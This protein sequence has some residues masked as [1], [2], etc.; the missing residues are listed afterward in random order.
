MVVDLA[1][2]VARARVAPRAAA[3]DEEGVYPEDI[4]QVFKEA[5]LLGLAV[6]E[7]YGGMGMGTLGLVLAVEEVAKYCCASGLILLLTRL[8]LAPIML[9][10][11]EEQKQKYARGIAEGRVR[12][13]FGLTE[14]DCGSDAAAIRTTAVRRGDHYVLNGTKRFISGTT[15]A[16]FFTIAAKTDPAAGSRGLSLLV[17][18]KGTSGLSL[19][20]K[21]NKMGVRGVPVTEIIMEDCRVPAENLL[22]QENQGFKTVMHTLNS[23]RP[24]VASRGIGLAE[25]ALQ[26]GIDYARER[27]A[28]GQP[29]IEFQGLQW[30]IADMAIATEASRL[31]TYRAAQYVD[32]GKYTREY[33]H[34]LSMAKTMA[35]DTAVR[36]ATDALQLLG[37]NGYMKEYPMERFYRDAKQ[38]QIVEGINQIQRN[39]IAKSIVDGHLHW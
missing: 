28:F 23:L 22:G 11:T 26:Y 36:V 1:R 7:E 10:G 3:I 8:P 16:D 39:I 25:G 9:A 27:K 21:E 18:D 33:A 17:V 32:E 4:F 37:G 15:V 29:V 34:F 38:L 2:R 6:P 13:A 19:G 14:P 31:L 24:V 35:T 20:K 5:G 12:G 30:M